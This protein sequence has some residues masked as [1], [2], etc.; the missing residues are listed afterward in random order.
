M[1]AL[2][3]LEQPI[4]KCVGRDEPKGTIEEQYARLVRMARSVRPETHLPRGVFFFSSF[5]EADRWER[6]QMMAR[7][8]TDFPASQT[9]PTHPYSGRTKPCRRQILCD[10]RLCRHQQTRREKD[11]AD[12]VFIRERLSEQAI[13]RPPSPTAIYL[14]AWM[15]KIRGWLQRKP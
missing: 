7:A 14:P 12:L 9:S 1:S 6:Q 11:A 8:R 10:R 13:E 15:E 5:E 2:S 3:H 4:G